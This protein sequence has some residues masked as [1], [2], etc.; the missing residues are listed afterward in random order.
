MTALSYFLVKNFIEACLETL[1]IR[2]NISNMRRFDDGAIALIKIFFLKS[3]LKI[4][5]MRMLR[6]LRTGQDR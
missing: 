4:Q 6:P 2:L 5:I 3:Q 1:Q